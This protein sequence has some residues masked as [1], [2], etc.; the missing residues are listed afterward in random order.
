M[1]GFEWGKVV[2]EER[3]GD[4]GMNSAA[5][6]GLKGVK[7]DRAPPDEVFTGPLAGEAERAGIAEP[8]GNL[9]RRFNGLGMEVEERKSLSQAKTNR[10]ELG[11]GDG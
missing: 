3:V 10:G 1:G 9:G 4:E 2:Q 11:V 7:H 8:K 5:E 6:D